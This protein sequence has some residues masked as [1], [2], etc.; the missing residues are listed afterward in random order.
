MTPQ[1]ATRLRDAA[2]HERRPLLAAFIAN[3]AARLLGPQAAQGLEPTKP[4]QDLGLDSLMAVELR[5]VLG[6]AIGQT[7]PAALL[8]NYPTVSGLAGHL[9][10]QVLH[11]AEVEASEAK[12]AATGKAD[13]ILDSVEDISDEEVER[14]LNE[15]TSGNL[16]GRP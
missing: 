9:L 7:L 16:G 6:Q 15:M 14:L 13:S 1:L 8:F 3:E 10:E 4:L 11:L 2:P 12:P 5:N